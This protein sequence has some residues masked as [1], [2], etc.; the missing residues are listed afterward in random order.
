MEGDILTEEI[1][2]EQNNKTNILYRYL[3]SSVY[4]IL[5]AMLTFMGFVTLFVLANVVVCFFVIFIKG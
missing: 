2:R 5:F 1:I 3:D 4:R